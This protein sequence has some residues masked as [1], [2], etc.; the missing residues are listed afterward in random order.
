MST[1][2]AAISSPGE[3]WEGSRESCKG[4]LSWILKDEQ[5]LA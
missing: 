1:D 2:T 5:E 4:Q 3:E